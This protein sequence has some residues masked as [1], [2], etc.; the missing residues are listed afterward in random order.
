LACL[1]VP[2][3]LL[4]RPCPYWITL[5]IAHRVYQ[6]HRF[7]NNRVKP[8]FPEVTDAF[9]LLVKVLRVP[10]MRLADGLGK[11]CAFSQQYY[12]MNEIGRR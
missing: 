4:Y 7:K 12:Q 9:L 3:G 6:I 8:V 1:R 5:D 11:Q 2:L 10:E